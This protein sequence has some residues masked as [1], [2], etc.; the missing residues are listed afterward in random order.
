M[1]NEPIG[2]IL[3]IARCVHKSWHFKVGSWHWVDLAQR[4][5]EG[6]TLSSF[7]NYMFVRIGIYLGT[8]LNITICSNY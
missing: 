7:G 8:Y 2:N 3:E 5:R 4:D 1:P 6:A